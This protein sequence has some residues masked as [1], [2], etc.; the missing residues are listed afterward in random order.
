M[1]NLKETSPKTPKASPAVKVPQSSAKATKSECVG[2]EEGEGSEVYQRSDKVFEAEQAV[3]LEAEDPEPG[4]DV[5]VVDLSESFH[6]VAGE[7]CYVSETGSEGTPSEKE[8]INHGNGAGRGGQ[9]RPVTNGSSNGVSEVRGDLDVMDSFPTCS[10][11]QIRGKRARKRKRFADEEEEEEGGMQVALC[12]QRGLRSPG[13]ET[14]VLCTT[15]RNPQEQRR[16]RPRDKVRAQEPVEQGEGRTL[17]RSP[18]N[19]NSSSSAN[20]STEHSYL[21]FD[22]S[23]PPAE[24]LGLLEEGV[25]VPGHLRPLTMA[26][27]K[28]PHGWTKKVVLRTPVKGSQ[29]TKWDVVIES[30]E[31]RVFR[32][33]QEL[34]RHFEEAGLEHNLELFDFNLDTQL[35]KIRQIWKAGCGGDP[36]SVPLAA[37][38]E[39]RVLPPSS[40]QAKRPA[41][42]PPTEQE[43]HKLEI[44]MRVGPLSPPTP[45][46]GTASET[47]QGVR[48]PLS[49]C[50]KL[51]RNEKLLL[52]HVKHYHPEYT[53][54]A[55][56]SP[57]VTELAFQRTR[58][59]E[60]AEAGGA[61]T[62]RSGG[63]R[64]KPERP[65]TEKLDKPKVDKPKVE[66]VEVPKTEKV[67]KLKVDEVD[68]PIVPK[69]EKP[70]EADNVES[71]PEV[72]ASL[73]MESS[74]PQSP[75]PKACSTPPPHKRLS[76][77]VKKLEIGEVRLYSTR[78]YFPHEGG[79]R[80]ESRLYCPRTK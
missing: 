60:E 18:Q 45:T 72:P 65:R 46:I 7:A 19:N 67:V 35:K 32:S 5:E 34:A 30:G 21:A 24:L 26:A 58:A 48:C 6:G 64:Y 40:P 36:Q 2:S 49:N 38:A 55:G 4:G 56:Y 74:A 52:Q 28:L 80:G 41:R 16:P 13:Q 79:H 77:D 25:S 71:K 63:E 3:R 1:L 68:Q 59:G 43:R 75:P 73:P 53:D 37:E 47:G 9:A 33:R 44:T 29:A 66:K 70:A 12:S 17:V 23:L 61:G 15:A 22:F 10:P 57:S 51:F 11:P 76:V 54:I 14:R 27:P 69:I 50:N 39:A 78:R 20:G 42:L 62:R 8:N 31:G